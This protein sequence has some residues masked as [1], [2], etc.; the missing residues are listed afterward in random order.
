[1]SDK[2]SQEE[3]VLRRLPD[4]GYVVIQSQLRVEVF[5][6][7]RIDDALMYIKQQIEPVS[8]AQQPRRKDGIYSAGGEWMS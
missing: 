8:Q 7:T 5:A 2:G 1:M 3:L 6:A 4:G